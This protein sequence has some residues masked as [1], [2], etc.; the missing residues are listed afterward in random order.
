M[1]EHET[2]GTNR[3]ALPGT[4]E[5]FGRDFQRRH[6]D[7]GKAN[8]VYLRLKWMLIH[9]RFR[10]GQQLHIGELVE[11]LATSATPLREALTRLHAERLVTATPNKG[12]FAKILSSREMQSWYELAFLLLKQ[13]LERKPVLMKRE[14][15]L[16]LVHAR[17]HLQAESK[18]HPDR[19][20]SSYCHVIETIFEHISY[21][22]CNDVI[23]DYVRNFN[24]QT[25]FVRAIDLEIQGN[26]E[27]IVG[28]MLE[29]LEELKNSRADKAIANLKSQFTRKIARLDDLAKEGNARSLASESSHVFL[30]DISQ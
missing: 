27:F 26:L 11:K 22:S 7:T 5:N 21:W 14:D 18:C 28:D 29:L 20:V 25:R 8:N 3:G 10:P 2:A 30:R 13:S 9:Y 16:V 6:H 1:E 15:E 4:L 17:V 23:I 12:F 19:S 24:S